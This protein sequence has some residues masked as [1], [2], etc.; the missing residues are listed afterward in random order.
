M[1]EIRQLPTAEPASHDSSAES[2]TQ[3][4]CSSGICSPCVIVWGLLGAVLLVNAL[5]EV[6]R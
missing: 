5:L 4:T 1:S 2:C 3:G 6:I